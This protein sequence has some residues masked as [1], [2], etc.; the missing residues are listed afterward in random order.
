MV[1]AW[2]LPWNAKLSR[3]LKLTVVLET[4]APK[5]VSRVR[6]IADGKFEE[7]RPT[8]GG[9]RFYDGG[10][11]VVLECP[12]EYTLVLTSERIGNTAI[13]LGAGQSITGDSNICIGK[14]VFGVPGENNTIRIGDNLPNAQSACFIGGIFQEFNN[15]IVLWLHAS[16]LKAR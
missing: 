15:R 5:R 9:F 4:C 6:V 16:S 8:H 12:N 10:T 14:G 11:T 1:S 13:G 7:T 3:L 2:S